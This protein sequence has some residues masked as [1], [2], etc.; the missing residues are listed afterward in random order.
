MIRRGRSRSP[1]KVEPAEG[2]GP[3]RGRDLFVSVR[4]NADVEA[5]VFHAHSIVLL[6]YFQAGAFRDHL[7]FA[8]E[9]DEDSANTVEL[10]GDPPHVWRTLL[11]LIYQ[12]F[13]LLY[14]ENIRCHTSFDELA[15]DL[16]RKHEVTTDLLELAL[17]THTHDCSIFHALIEKRYSRS[18]EMDCSRW[19]KS[20]TPANA[21]I[22]LRCGM[23]DAVESW[24][25]CEQECEPQDIPCNRIT[26]FLRDCI[27]D[28]L[29]S[30][31]LTGAKNILE[32]MK[33]EEDR[34]KSREGADSESDDEY[35]V[36]GFRHYWDENFRKSGYSN[37]T[38][39]KI[40]QMLEVIME[41]CEA[42]HGCAIAIR[43]LCEVMPK[44]IDASNW[45][46]F[47][48]EQSLSP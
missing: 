6:K 23:K 28:E 40:E 45:D 41:T 16:L 30:V 21:G 13:D 22:L 2:V 11:G 26:N 19:K 48:S 32:N 39:A 27:D 5:V 29:R 9:S 12:H 7:A 18:E 42:R 10:V 8:E 14:D 37:N 35:Q 20:W 15:D 33:R 3:L 38:I 44:C 34:K 4:A 17:L 43:K 47:V 24:F 36:H 31:A 25:E 1:K 46:A